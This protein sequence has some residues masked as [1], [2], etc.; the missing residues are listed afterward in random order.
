[1]AYEGWLVGHARWFHCEAGERFLNELR[2]WAAERKA[3]RK[4]I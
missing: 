1:M 3:L 4:E 2:R